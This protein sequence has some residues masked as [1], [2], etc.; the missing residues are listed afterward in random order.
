MVG[1]HFRLSLSFQPPPQ[2]RRDH[3]RRQQR[4]DLEGQGPVSRARPM[5]SQALTLRATSSPPVDHPASTMG[6][7]TLATS[8]LTSNSSSVPPAPTPSSIAERRMVFAYL[9]HRTAFCRS[10]TCRRAKRFRTAK[11]EGSKAF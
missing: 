2:C 6:S 3:I 11:V 7:K 8:S 1:T 4:E 9:L 10:L 5:L